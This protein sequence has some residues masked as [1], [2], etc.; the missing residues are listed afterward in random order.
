MTIGQNTG[1]GPLEHL[2]PLDDTGSWREDCPPPQPLSVTHW[3]PLAEDLWSEEDK[4]GRKMLPCAHSWTCPQFIFF[5][6]Y[7]PKHWTRG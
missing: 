2:G 7:P 1:Q 5:L 3:T 6:L 4:K